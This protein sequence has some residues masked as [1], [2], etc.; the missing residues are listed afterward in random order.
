MADKGE[1]LNVQAL[2]TLK[3]LNKKQYDDKI[4]E[5]RNEKDIQKISE[6]LKKIAQ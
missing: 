5:M 3:N 6:K 1:G 4:R 2:I